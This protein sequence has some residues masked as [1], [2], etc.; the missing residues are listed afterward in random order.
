MSDSRARPTRLPALNF[1]LSNKKEAASVRDSLLYK[2]SIRI[3]LY[4]AT[5][6]TL[7]SD[8]PPCAIWTK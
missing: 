7:L 2:K 6:T 4:L 1:L 5:I 8:K 3:V